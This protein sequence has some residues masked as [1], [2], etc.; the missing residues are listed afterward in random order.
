VPERPDR[1]AAPSRGRSGA[2]VVAGTNVTPPGI[3]ASSMQ[4]HCEGDVTA[5]VTLRQPIAACV[6]AAMLALAACSGGSN[7][8]STGTGGASITWEIVDPDPASEAGPASVIAWGDGYLGT[9]SGLAW[10]S[11]DAKAWTTTLLPGA[12]LANEMVAVGRGL[13]AAGATN[14]GRL[15]AIWTSSDEVMWS[16]V[17]DAD[18]APASGF[19]ATSISSLAAGPGGIVAVGTEWGDTGQRPAAWWSADGVDWVRSTEPL[20]GSGARDVAVLGDGFVIVGAG[21]AL[22]NEETRAEFWFSA[23]GRSWTPVADD[24]VRGGKEP[25]AVAASG[26]GLVSVGYRMGEPPGALAPMAWT[27]GDGRTWSAVVPSEDMS[28]WPYPGARPIVDE[29]A[30]WGSS[31]WDVAAFPSELLAVGVSFGL[32]PV[33]RLPDGTHQMMSTRA[34]WRS[35]DGGTWDLMDPGLPGA[36]WEKAP[37]NGIGYGFQRIVNVNGRPIVIG[38]TS[39]GG[40][41]LW[42]GTF[43]G[44]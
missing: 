22:A 39:A 44:G 35:T 32:D 8:A 10:A 9:G 23:D 27:S 19:Q 40:L 41:Q 15:A 30:M 21:N 24:G 37:P 18:L 13:V 31:M 28:P 25:Q 38:S 20:V 14:D 4:P 6:V 12:V 26:G 16:A 17:N 1:L 5:V 34:V 43:A 7:P 3:A 2:V 33:A 42:L 29:G 11:K 36:G